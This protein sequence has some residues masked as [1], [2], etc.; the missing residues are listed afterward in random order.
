MWL[1]WFVQPVM[2]VILVRSVLVVISVKRVSD[3][4]L[5]ISVKRKS[6]IS[7]IHLRYRRRNDV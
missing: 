4:I 3:V 5:V 1:V 6:V 2:F 7:V